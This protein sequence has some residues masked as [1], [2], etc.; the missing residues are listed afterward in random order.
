MST[1]FWPLLSISINTTTTFEQKS[2]LPRQFIATSAEVTPRGSF[3]RESNPKWPKK[4]RL[5]IYNNLPR[6]CSTFF[7]LQVTIG[8]SQKHEPVLPC[9]SVG[10]CSPRFSRH[11]VARRGVRTFPAVRKNNKHLWI[12][13]SG[14]GCMGHEGIQQENGKSYEPFITPPSKT[15][16]EMDNYLVKYIFKLLVF[17]L[18]MLFFQGVNP[19]WLR[20]HDSQISWKKIPAHPSHRKEN[21]VI[22]QQKMSIKYLINR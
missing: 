13:P 7:V 8:S 15:N 20:F 19:R 22:I 11:A 21:M 3:G 6:P 18:V 12:A 10:L 4:F 16:M 17:Q 1:N 14:D 9:I 2:T 5:G